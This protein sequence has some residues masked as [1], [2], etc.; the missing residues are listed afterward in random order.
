MG[1]RRPLACEAEEPEASEP[2]AGWQDGSVIS[3]QPPSGQG[4]DGADAWSVP[5]PNEDLQSPQTIC[6]GD[7]NPVAW[8]RWKEAACYLDVIA[9]GPEMALRVMNRANN[10]PAPGTRRVIWCTGFG[11]P[12]L[13][14]FKAIVA[15][16]PD[17]EAVSSLVAQWPGDV[18]C[19]QGTR[20]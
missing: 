7:E 1:W 5:D 9:R 18:L 2:E 19:I 10:S 13:Y 14:I 15:E 4:G 3:Q 16:N 17:A 11:S 12:T 6:G 20:G 8:A